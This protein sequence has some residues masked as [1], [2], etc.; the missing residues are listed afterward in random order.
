MIPDFVIVLLTSVVRISDFDLVISS[1]ILRHG[2]PLELSISTAKPKTGKVF[3]ASKSRILV[4]CPHSFTLHSLINFLIQVRDHAGEYW[5][6]P[7]PFEQVYK[8]GRVSCV[9]R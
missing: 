7:Q 8:N 2:G 3:V 5:G 4:S 1:R 6:F 9:H